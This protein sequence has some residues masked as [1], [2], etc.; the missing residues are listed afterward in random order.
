MRPLSISQLSSAFLSALLL[1]AA[2]CTNA[3]VYAL[4]GGGV[5]GPDRTA[6]E[7]T[8]CVPLAKG[9]A[10]PVK[11]VFAVEGGTTTVP[12]PT[13]TAMINAIQNI[14]GLLPTSTSYTFLTYHVTAEGFQGGFGP[15]TDLAAALSLYPTF[16]E[17]GPVSITSALQLA[18][19]F[20]S[21]D[22][23]V[24]CRGTVNRTRYLVV[25]LEST[26][27]TS[28]LYPSIYA[29]ID[30]TCLALPD[31]SQCAACELQKITGDLK[32]LEQQFNAGEVTVQPIYVTDTAPPDSDLTTII[33]PAISQSGGSQPLVATSTTINTVLAGVNFASLQRDLALKRFFAFNR[34]ALARRGQQLI[35][36]DG[37][38][39]SDD[40]E[41]AGGTDPLNPDTDGDG[42]NDGLERKMGLDP[43][44]VNTVTSCNPFLDTD[45][46]KLNDCEER[47]LGTDSC[48][49]DTDGD[50]FSD[51]V[52]FDSQ[53]N[54]Q[55][56]EDL[57]DQDRDGV[58][59]AAEVMAHSDALSADQDYQADRGYQYH[60]VDAQPTVDGRACYTVR[61]DNVSLVATKSRPNPPLSPIPDG[62]NEIY[63]FLQ[64]G[65]TNDP[66][67]A[68]IASV[69]TTEVN[70]KPPSTKSPSGVIGYG[71][72]DFV[73]GQ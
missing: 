32:A 41:I 15:V 61:V 3:G 62:N 6:F 48:V 47:V 39:L 11:V 57:T 51:F 72:D 43:L 50:G 55:V 10:F 44:V 38:G 26:R 60:I 9:D 31:P 67:G 52:E 18:K 13:G 59:N 16:Q 66:H 25:L 37:D 34:N 2:G 17:S 45:Q 64:S 49:A 30:S 54:P 21:G 69:L 35:D 5:P 33:N 68:G 63:L 14:V 73:V 7:G 28:C 58:S 53:T 40:E 24:S 42:I 27:D 1:G 46:D 8:V 19:S 29:G 22:M 4:E 23:Q 71:P 36:S 20:I 65:R 12:Q 70:F 56:A